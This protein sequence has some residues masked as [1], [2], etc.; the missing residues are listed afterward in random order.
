MVSLSRPSHLDEV[1]EELVDDEVVI[2]AGGQ[3]VVVLMNLGMLS[4]RKLVSI[5]AVDQLRGVFVEQGRV[6]VGAL[7]THG[8]LASDQRIRSR[9]PAAADMFADIGNVRV[10][11]T[12]TIGGNLV[13]ADPAQD[14]PVLLSALQ[15]EA[16]VVGRNSE[17]TIPVEQLAVGPMQTALAFDEVLTRI[18]I[19]LLGVGVECSYKKL[20][21]GSWDDYPT[22]SVAARIAFDAAGIVTEARLSAGGV[23]PTVLLLQEAAALLIGKDSRDE[24]AIAELMPC[25]RE[26]VSPMSDRRGSEDYKREMAA[27][28]A[29][30]VVR[31]CALERGRTAKVGSTD[32]T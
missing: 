25:V 7:S 10:R 4:P 13:Q 9:F 11:T 28:L 20:L 29:A 26:G 1:L 2:L 5:A 22:V 14:P 6:D 15:A 18:R 21:P 3:A 19:P 31:S 12:G 17:R 32:A 30:K 23:G 27:L 24:D 8:A 16:L